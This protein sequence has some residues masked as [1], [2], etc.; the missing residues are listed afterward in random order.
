M[1][2]KRLI[3]L[4]LFMDYLWIYVFMICGYDR[5]LWL[6]YRSKIL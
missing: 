1:P 6:K 2:L 5:D 3:D 4:L